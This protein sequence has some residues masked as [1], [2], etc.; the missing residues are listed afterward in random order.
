MRHLV[1]MEFN[2]PAIP[3]YWSEYV[4]KATCVAAAHT[5]MCGEPEAYYLLFLLLVP[6]KTKHKS[7][8]SS[9]PFSNIVQCYMNEKS[10]VKVVET[11]M[12]SF[13]KAVQVFSV[14][15]QSH[16]SACWSSA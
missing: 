9:P 10:N 6:K 14:V 16:G 5:R 15:A 11:L 8:L 1:D 4:N 12:Q 3:E 13:Q 2:P 7:F